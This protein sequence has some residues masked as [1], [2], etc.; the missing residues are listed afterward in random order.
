MEKLKIKATTNAERCEICHQTDQFE[1]LTNFCGRCQPVGNVATPASRPLHSH[2]AASVNLSGIHPGFIP[3]I[4][5]NYCDFDA[6]IKVINKYQR[7]YLAIVLI[8]F[9]ATFAALTLISLLRPLWGLIMIAP[10]TAGA[11]VLAL[12]GLFLLLLFLV[13]S[14]LPIDQIKPSL[15]SEPLTLPEHYRQLTTLLASANSY[16]IE[17]QVRFDPSSHNRTE[18]DYWL[19]L[20]TTVP[21]SPFLAGS[22][23]PIL[24][25]PA[26]ILLPVGECFTGYL[27]RQPT[28]NEFVI[29]FQNGLLVSKL[30]S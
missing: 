10:L 24:P 9:L 21:E 30:A 5:T 16:P 1:P 18:H 7:H 19:E 22:K 13:H 8:A 20:F 17:C 26:T 23:W 6:R 3:Y 15:P 14:I 4:Y 27:Y 25:P 12:M 29:L 11:L 28:T 2:Y